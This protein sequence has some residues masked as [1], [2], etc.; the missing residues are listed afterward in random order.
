MYPGI[1]CLQYIVPVYQVVHMTKYLASF[2]QE[3][4][5]NLRSITPSILYEMSLWRMI[6]I[7]VRSEVVV[8]LL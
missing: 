8:V 2:T 5:E 4:Q 1:V 3:N 7:G 6:E